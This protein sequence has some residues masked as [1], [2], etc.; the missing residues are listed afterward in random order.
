MSDDFDPDYKTDELPELRADKHLETV[1]RFVD[2]QNRWLEMAVRD[3]HD[4]RRSSN[5]ARVP[6][7]F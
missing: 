3:I 4:G 6:T 5:S 1:K 7:V 2:P